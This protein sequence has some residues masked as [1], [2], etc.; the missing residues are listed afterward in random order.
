[1]V[2][3]DQRAYFTINGNDFPF[4]PIFLAH[5]NTLK[6]V[7]RF[8]DFLYH[9]NKRSLNFYFAHVNCTEVLWRFFFFLMGEYCGV[10]RE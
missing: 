2:L 7:K 6:G 4:D 3:Q 8:P 1:M 5:P 9:Q 10:K